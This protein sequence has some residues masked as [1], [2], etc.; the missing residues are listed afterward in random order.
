MTEQQNDT[1]LLELKEELNIVWQDGTTDSRLD[2]TLNRS[3]AFL[4]NLF[5]V[6]LDYIGDLVARGLALSYARY[7][8]NNATEYFEE[9]FHSEILRYSLQLASREGDL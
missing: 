1:L 9:N 8:W 6:E 4:N 3:K 5:G 2:N 7:D